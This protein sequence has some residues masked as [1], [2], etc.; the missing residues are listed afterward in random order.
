[1]TTRI[2]ISGRK[3]RLMKISLEYL[4]QNEAGFSL[5]EAHQAVIEVERE[6]PV[7]FDIADEKASSFIERAADV[8]AIASI[9]STTDDAAK[10]P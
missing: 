8:G 9:L 7:E 1:M 2:K 5:S 3:S 10:T 4:L 6:Q